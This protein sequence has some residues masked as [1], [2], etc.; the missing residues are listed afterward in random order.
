MG[1]EPQLVVERS[2]E[3]TETPLLQILALSLTCPKPYTHRSL[4]SSI[5]SLDKCAHLKRIHPDPPLI[6]WQWGADS[7]RAPA[8]KGCRG[9]AQNSPL[10]IGSLLD[11][12]KE[13]KRICQKTNSC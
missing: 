11:D 13:R 1:A 12:Q 2:P 6:S 9:V 4:G 10:G 8:S 5:R 7:E 3:R